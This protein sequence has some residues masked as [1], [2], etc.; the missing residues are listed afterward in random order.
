MEKE[1]K[2]QEQKVPAV[3]NAKLTEEVR[4]QELDRVREI[5]AI[6]S[7]HNLRSFADESIKSGV[8]VA[9]FKGL[10]LEKIG[11][12]KPLETPVDSVDMNEKEQKEYSLTRMIN[13]QMSGN[14]KCRF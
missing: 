5:S 12:E 14:Y 10:V 8:S 1:N 9:Q 4:K 3:D 13:A 7:R 6:G 11:N 2:I